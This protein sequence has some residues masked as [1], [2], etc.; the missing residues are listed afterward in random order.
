MRR[1]VR[2]DK[3]NIMIM[4]AGA[5][6]VLAGFGIL[7]I[8]IGRQLVTRSQLQNAAD[9][10]ALAGASV[11][12]ENPAATDAEVQYRAKLLGAAN[13]ALV[14]EAV[15]VDMDA[16]KIKLPA[17]VGPRL[18]CGRARRIFRSVMNG[19]KM[20]QLHLSGFKFRYAF[21]PF[22]AVGK[23]ERLDGNG[24]LARLQRHDDGR[25]GLAGFV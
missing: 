22:K 23:L 3:G 11:F 7:T 12:C 20:C 16:A 6:A 5:M 13:E 14:N 17:A 4:M 15:P 24:P 10:S 25:L 18:P 9:A 8:D 1:W 19:A 21:N 2:S